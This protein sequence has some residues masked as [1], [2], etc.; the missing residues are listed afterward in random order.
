MNNKFSLYKSLLGLLSIISLLKCRSVL[1][2]I[3]ACNF[4]T[5]LEYH[6]YN[7]SLLERGLF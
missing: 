3:F 5:M 4:V 1:P 7:F 6:H 2:L